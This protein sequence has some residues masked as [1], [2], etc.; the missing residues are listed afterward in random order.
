MKLR[1]I[2][3]YGPAVGQYRPAIATNVAE[4]LRKARRRMEL[5]EFDHWADAMDIAEHQEN[6]DAN[7]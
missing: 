2:H 7:E 3:P 6:K 1:Q 5:C 4:T